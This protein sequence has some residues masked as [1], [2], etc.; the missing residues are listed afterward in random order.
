MA[1][2]ENTVK[3][4]TD[5]ITIGT[6]TEFKEDLRVKAVLR[7]YNL[8]TAGYEIL[9]LGLPIWLKKRPVKVKMKDAA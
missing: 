1:Q 3:Q 6:P 5:N 9:Q 7:G 8:S 4:D 2:E